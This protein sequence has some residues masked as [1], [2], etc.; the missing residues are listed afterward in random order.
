MATLINL[1][2]M[3]YLRIY[4]ARYFEL[5]PHLSRKHLAPWLIP[6]AIGRLGERIPGEQ[7]SLMVLIDNT[8]VALGL[9]SSQSKRSTSDR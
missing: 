8:L 1:W 9:V 4:L 7:G 2:R 5:H 6:V 3:F